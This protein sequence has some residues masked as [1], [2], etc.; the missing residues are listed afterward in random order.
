MKTKLRQN[1]NKFAGERRITTFWYNIYSKISCNIKI[2]NSCY[3]HFANFYASASKLRR[4]SMIVNYVI[5]LEIYI[6]VCERG[7]KE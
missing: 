5:Q 4:H 6:Y 3:S 2:T 1:N 7:K